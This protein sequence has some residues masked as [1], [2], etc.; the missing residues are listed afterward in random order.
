MKEQ[1]SIDTSEEKV[2]TMKE[3]EEKSVETRVKRK[4]YNAR[5]RKTEK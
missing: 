4:F 5:T 3:Q 2:F 1:K